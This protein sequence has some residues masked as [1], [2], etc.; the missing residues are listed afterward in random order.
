MTATNLPK[1]RF[2]SVSIHLH[3]A[4]NGGVGRCLSGDTSVIHTLSEPSVLH[5][6]GCYNVV[7]VTF[8]AAIY[9]F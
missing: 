4:M 1:K 3:S 5:L 7:F 2:F 6:C 9:C 8:L